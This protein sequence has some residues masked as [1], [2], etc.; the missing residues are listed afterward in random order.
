MIYKNFTW[1]PFNNDPPQNA[2]TVMMVN[3]KKAHRFFTDDKKQLQNV[4]HILRSYNHILKE[5]LLVTPAL[6]LIGKFYI[7]QKPF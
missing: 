5:K 7:L 4:N 6:K 1:V 3:V 2:N